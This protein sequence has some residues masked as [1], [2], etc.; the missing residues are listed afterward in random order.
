M[1]GLLIRAAGWRR[2]FSSLAATAD[3]GTPGTSTA[4]FVKSSVASVASFGGYLGTAALCDRP[5]GSESANMVGLGVSAGGN[6]Y[7]QMKA[8]ATAA[9]PRYVGG[10][11]AM[12]LRYIAA[13]ATI[14]AS[15]HGLFV[16]ASRAYTPE[17]SEGLTAVRAFAQL[18]VFPVLSFPIRKYWVFR[19][20]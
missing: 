8:F 20:V 11:Q 2:R 10:V 12:V 15:Q 14:V 9:A 16:A 13:E 19:T 6:F 17:T 3:R 1:A 7:M 18:S 5:L 4:A